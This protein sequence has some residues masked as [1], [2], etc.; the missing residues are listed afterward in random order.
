MKERTPP[1]RIEIIGSEDEKARIFRVIDEAFTEEERNI[2]C[3]YSDVTVIVLKKTLNPGEYIHKKIGKSGPLI[4]IRQGARDDTIVHEFVHH[5]RVMDN[6]RIGICRTPVAVNENGELIESIIHEKHKHDIKAV[7]ETATIAETTVRRH[8]IGG[9]SGY[10][11]KIK[12][13]SSNDAYIHDRLLLTESRSNSLRG[14]EAVDAVNRLFDR[15][16]IS[17]ACISPEDTNG[18]TAKESRELL[19]KEGIMKNEKEEVINE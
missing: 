5:L 6:N 2:M 12:G 8:S 4:I 9:V 16:K 13:I 19:V 17:D 11:S 14:E 1:V 18:R 10:F 3:R 15:T 7:E